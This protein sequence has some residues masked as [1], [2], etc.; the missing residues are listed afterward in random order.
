MHLAD[1][2]S[3]LTYIAFN[4]HLIISQG[5]ETMILVS[6]IYFQASINSPKKQRFQMVVF[7]MMP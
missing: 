5:I 6:C 2:S 1:V 3:K 4:V 7:A